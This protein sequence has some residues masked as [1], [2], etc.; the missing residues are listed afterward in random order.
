MIRAAITLKLNA[1]DDTGAIVA[2][3]TTS[4]PEAPGSGRNWDYRY[5]WLRDA[6]LR[7]QRAQP[8]RRD[9]HDGALPGLHR[10]RRRRRRRHAAAAGLS[11][12]RAGRAGGARSRRAA[13]LSRHGAGARSATRP[14]RRCSTTCTARRSWPPPTSSSTGAW[15]ARGDE[16]LFRR[17]ESL[18]E[19]RAAVHDQPDAG[20]WEL[21]GSVARPHLLHRD[22]LGGL[23]PS[24]THRRAAGARRRRARYW[25]ERADRIHAVDLRAGLERAARQL[26][27][28][29]STATRSTR[30][31]CCCTSSVS[32][33]RTIRASPARW[34]RS[35][36]SCK[37]GD[38]IFRYVEADDF[39][40]PE[41]AFIVCTFWYINALAALGRTRGG[42]RAVREA[43]RLPQ[44]P[45]PAGRAHRSA[46]RRAVGQ[47]RADLQH[48]RPDQ[49]GDPAQHPLGPGVLGAHR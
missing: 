45:R 43:A 4:I 30:A 28:R 15:R 29:P 10:Q 23:R 24:G 22:V 2:A 33:R 9:A 42:A 47:L 14:T 40:V 35:S 19:R 36:A 3:M 17:L 46:N 48:G 16:A 8:P 37:Q 41:N 27:R 31:C 12:R 5:C 32:W 20:L 38:F 21:R 39:G 1:F 25:R 49:R 34:P 7:G 18:G 11:H 26:R 44:P 6:L 13:R